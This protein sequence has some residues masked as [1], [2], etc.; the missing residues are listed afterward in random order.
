MTLFG[1]STAVK[2]DVIKKRSVKPFHLMK[3]IQSVT[4][5]FLS[6][7][8]LSKRLTLMTFSK[9]QEKGSVTLL[10]HRKMDH[11]LNIQ[12]MVHYK[13]VCKNVRNST[14]AKISCSVHL[15]MVLTSVSTIVNYGQ[16]PQ[17]NQVSQLLIQV[18]L[19]V[20]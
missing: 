13:N 4:Q 12:L 8:Q 16:L 6:Q 20:T 19:L 7:K 10:Q 9:N 11:R 18:E 5:S 15:L 17:L 2:I 3:K 1:L 14:I